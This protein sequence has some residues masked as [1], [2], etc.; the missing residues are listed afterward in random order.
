MVQ[1]QRSPDDIQHIQGEEKRFSLG[2]KNKFEI[3]PK[4]EDGNEDGE[5]PGN[6]SGF[7]PTPFHHQHE[8]ENDNDGGKS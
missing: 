1:Q 6:R 2:I 7:A 3:S 8:D 5:P 4:K